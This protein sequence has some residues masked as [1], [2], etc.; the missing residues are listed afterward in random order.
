MKLAEKLSEYVTWGQFTFVVG[1]IL[2][3]ITILFNQIDGAKKELAIY[4]DKL[5][6]QVQVLSKDIS[7]LSE[8]MGRIETNIDNIKETLNGA[9]IQR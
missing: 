8:R 9:E 4:N 3:L 5:F 2:A 1:I 6:N 7:G